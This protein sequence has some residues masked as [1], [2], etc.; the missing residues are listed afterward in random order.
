MQS[1]ETGIF[2]ELNIPLTRRHFS[3]MV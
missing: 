3:R 1:R 2:R